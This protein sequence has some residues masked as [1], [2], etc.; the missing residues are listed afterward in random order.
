MLDAG[1]PAGWLY[2]AICCEA[3]S[4]ETDGELTVAQVER[5]G[6]KGW[7]KRLDALVKVAAV[8]VSDGRVFVSAW[9]NHNDA[10]TEVRRR[11]DADAARK[12]AQGSARNPNGVGAD[13]VG[14]PDVEVET[15]GEVET[16]VPTTSGAVAPLPNGGQL[17][18]E[19]INLHPR[20]PPDRVV[21]KASKAVGDL[22][23]EGWAPDQIRA[24]LRA[25]A[26]RGMDPSVLPSLVN[27]AANT[28][29]ASRKP[30]VTETKV[31][32]FV[33]IAERLEA[34]GR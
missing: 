5:L 8:S 13:S 7:Q 23:A 29:P 12:A 4:M 15:E 3:K 20:R 32:G 31:A 21:G 19:W 27:Q 9:L 28:A 6:I 25:L 11:R 1:E 24:G 33:A 22:L 26:E 16:E 30:S 34:Q 10:S 18:K 14:I 17:I 2:L